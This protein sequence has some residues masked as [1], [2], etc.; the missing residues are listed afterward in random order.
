M[1]DFTGNVVGSKWSDNP[2]PVNITQTTP[3]LLF[4]TLREVVEM[5]SHDLQVS[6]WSP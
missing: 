5:V 4:M 6:G 2:V 1:T 3:T